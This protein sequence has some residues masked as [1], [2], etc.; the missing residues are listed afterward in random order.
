MSRGRYR[1][2]ARAAVPGI[3]PGAAVLPPGVVVFRKEWTLIDE[4][5]ES[6]ESVVEMESDR[7]ARAIQRMLEI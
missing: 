6:A 2:K 1:N 4:V 7:R 3:R 5:D